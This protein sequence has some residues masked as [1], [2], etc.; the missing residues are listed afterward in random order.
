[1]Q[2]ACGLAQLERAPIFVQQR[3]KNYS[4]LKERLA[5]CN[6]FLLLPEATPNSNPSWFGFPVTLRE[7]S[8]VNRL[9]LLQYLDQNKIGT[10]LLFA[11]NLTRQ[12]YMTGRNYRISGDIV[13]TDIAMN[14]TF[15]LGIYPGLGEAQFDYVAEKISNF[16][17][18]GF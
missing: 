4:L 13:N 17:G 16:L 15:W 3:K 10:R 1:M 5:V 9:D 11:G 14:D 8:P 18:I 7:S 2:A 6:K 12:P